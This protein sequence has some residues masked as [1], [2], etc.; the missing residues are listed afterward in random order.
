[1]NLPVPEIVRAD[2][3]SAWFWRSDA[4][5]VVSIAWGWPGGSRLD[6]PG[7]EGEAAF[8]AD[9]LTEGAGAL[10]ALAFQEALRDRAISLD[11]WVERDWFGGSLRCLAEALPEAVRLAALALSA[12]RF[13]GEAVQRVRARMIAG[14]RR[15]QEQPRA[16]S[17]RAFW[18]GVAPGNPIARPTRGTAESLAAAEPR[19]PA[20]PGPVLAAAAG[21]V[22]PATLAGALD[23]LLAG[24]APSAPAPELSDPRAFGRAV[25]RHAAS[26]SAIT[27]G[28]GGAGVARAGRDWDA[29]QVALRVLG[30][31]G[32]GARLMEAV[33]EQGGLAYGI[34]LGFQPL[35][36]TGLIVGGTATANA[37]VPRV[38]DLVGREWRRMAEG[39]PTETEVADSVAAMA[40]GAMRA[41]ADTRRAAGALLSARRLGREPGDIAARPARLRS[42]TV[43]D[44]AAAARAALDPAALSFAIAG[45]PEGL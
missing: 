41:F 32:F 14:A 11:F 30:G 21:S 37:N 8:G 35:A 38:L 42:L 23:L 36:G 16:L 24:G 7:R 3:G 19:M 22:A 20:R 1:M 5:P 25:V 18:E 29:A 33:R 31:G 34:S 6:P 45:E 27:F 2:A 15:E 43:Q 39:G 13:D 40:G 17:G 26:Q 12:P 28:H 4:A 44:V 9:L 10:D